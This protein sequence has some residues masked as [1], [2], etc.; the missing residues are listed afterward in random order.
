MREKHF[1]R[2]GQIPRSFSADRSGVYSWF[3]TDTLDRY[4]STS[5]YG[6]DSIT[7]SINEHGYRMAPIQE[8]LND[9]G[10]LRLVFYGC[11]LTFGVGVA[12]NGILSEKY[13]RRISIVR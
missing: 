2:R 13:Y 12:E 11:S 6:V 10:S 3:D 9:D 1:W 7:Y 4:D 8:A 5:G